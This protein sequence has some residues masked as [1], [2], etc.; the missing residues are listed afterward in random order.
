MAARRGFGPFGRNQASDGCNKQ[1]DS[2]YSPILITILGINVVVG[3]GTFAMP[4]ELVKYAGAAGILTIAIAAMCL[5]FIGFAIARVTF[6][7]PE[8]GS[9]YSYVNAWGGKSLGLMAIFSYMLG[10]ILCIGIL[11]KYVSNIIAIYATNINLDHIGYF[12]ILGMF[13]GMLLSSSFARN[14]NPLSVLT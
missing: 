3:A 1:G 11:I 12:I 14:R 5:L 10:L 8:H 7:V 2:L 9:F 4:I 13:L 6:L